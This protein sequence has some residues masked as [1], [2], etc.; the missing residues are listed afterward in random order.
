MR[1]LIRVGTLSYQLWRS[2]EPRYTEHRA[3]PILSSYPHSEH[4]TYLS[5]RSELPTLGQ[6]F[7]ISSVC[8]SVCGLTASPIEKL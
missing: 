7:D 5:E 2:R 3:T 8:L 1:R 4:T 6:G